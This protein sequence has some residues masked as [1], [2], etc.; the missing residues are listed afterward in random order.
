MRCSHWLTYTVPDFCKIWWTYTRQNLP[1]LKMRLCFWVFKF[2]RAFCLIQDVEIS[3][4]KLNDKYQESIN[5]L[6]LKQKAVVWYFI[7]R[8]D[9]FWGYSVVSLYPTNLYYNFYRMAEILKMG[10]FELFMLSTYSSMPNKNNTFAYIFRRFI[11]GFTIPLVP[12]IH[13]SRSVI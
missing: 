12:I 8:V 7:K 9:Y 6:W 5:I 4:S 3:E 10:L 11:L 2:P 13:K 1:L